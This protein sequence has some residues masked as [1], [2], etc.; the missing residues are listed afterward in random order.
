MLRTAWSRGTAVP[1]NSL[2]G[3]T[4]FDPETTAVLASAFDLAWDTV[5]N[6]GSPLA[7]DDQAVLTRELL[8]KRIIDKAQQGERDPKRLVDDALAHLAR[9][10]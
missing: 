7:A 5:K 2:L 1:F 9:S 4:G 6:S 3:K 8:A 10:N